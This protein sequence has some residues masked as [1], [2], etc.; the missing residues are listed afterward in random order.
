MR[1]SGTT[2]RENSKEFKDML[3][4]TDKIIRRGAI[5]HNNKKMLPEEFA[6]FAN[7]R[8][9]V[10]LSEPSESSTPEIVTAPLKEEHTPP[11]PK[12][13]NKAPA[14]APVR[15][16]SNA[17][18]KPLIL[19]P[20]ENRKLRNS[21]VIVE[22]NE[23]Q[24]LPDEEYNDDDEDEEEEQEEDVMDDGDYDD[25]DVEVEV[26]DDEMQLDEEPNK[27]QELSSPYIISTLQPEK[28]SISII[29]TQLNRQKIRMLQHRKPADY[30]LD[31]KYQTSD[32]DDWLNPNN[33]NYK[34]I[35]R[36]IETS[37]T[38]LS[39]KSWHPHRSNTKKN[40]EKFLK[41]EEF[42]ETQKDSTTALNKSNTT[43]LNKSN[44]TALDKSNKKLPAIKVSTDTKTPNRR[45]VKLTP[46]IG[47]HIDS[48][49]SKGKQ[50][51]TDFETNINNSAPYFICKHIKLKNKYS[52]NDI[53]YSRFFDDN[54]DNKQEDISDAF[55]ESK[56]MDPDDLLSCP[57]S[58]IEGLCNELANNIKASLEDNHDDYRNKH[59]NTSKS[60]AGKKC[61]TSF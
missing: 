4:I 22:A 31:D 17:K 61:S 44:T 9:R 51:Y 60:L 39:A 48:S 24:L 35:S 33:N 28:K 58:D 1:R 36:D 32:D 6:K 49:V 19:V 41:L 54:D 26:E 43:A 13:K 46:K 16:V 11:P 50:I 25:E 3:A 10:E 23:V 7:R 47:E 30:V 8:R 45:E 29:S 57:T 5:I 27:P 34:S 20:V 40:T 42:I 14:P 38:I 59:T 15:R 18:P 52:Y 21:K 53:D 37:Q 55:F 2:M 56:L 12:K